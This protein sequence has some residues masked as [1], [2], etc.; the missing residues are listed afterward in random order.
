MGKSTSGNWLSQN[1]Q[2]VIDT[3]DIARDLTRPDGPALSEIR[4]SFGDDVFESP[5]TLNRAALAKIIF[6]DSSKKRDLEKI[7]HPKIRAEWMRLLSQFEEQGSPFGFVIIPLLFEVG[8]ENDLDATVC[9]LSST[10][11][12]QERLANRGWTLE[13]ATARIQAQA[14]IVEKQQRADYVIWSEGASEG[15]DWQWRRVLERL[16]TPLP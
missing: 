16:A 9:I 11:T 10:R 12:Q 3:D 14:P 8:A 7:L 5:S 2:P 15:L 13:Q 6:R 1:S 4:R